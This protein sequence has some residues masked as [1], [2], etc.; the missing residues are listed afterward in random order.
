MD[1]NDKRLVRLSDSVAEISSGLVDSRRWMMVFRARMQVVE[2]TVADIGDQ[3]GGLDARFL[4][5]RGQALRASATSRDTVGLCE[6]LLEHAGA[7][8]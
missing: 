1:A 4:E 3:L 6:R 8:D 5:I 2:T 7:D